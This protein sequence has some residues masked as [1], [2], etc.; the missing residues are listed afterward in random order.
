MSKILNI[1]NK[2]LLF[3]KNQFIVLSKGEYQHFYIMLYI[4][5]L[6]PA[7]LIFF[8]LKKNYFIIL[9]DYVVIF[10]SLIIMAYFIWHIYVVKKTLKVQPQYIVKKIT[11]KELYAG[12]TP[13]EIKQIK[14]DNKIKTVKKLLLLESWDAM[15]M[16][17]IIELMDAIIVIF[18]FQ[19]IL[20]IID[21]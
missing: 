17:T 8:I 13:E 20:N 3:F 15:P 1:I 14:K 12:K 11:K 9:N 6:L 18:Q 21:K 16:Y 4:Y 10:I 7:I 5:S 19:R 2:F